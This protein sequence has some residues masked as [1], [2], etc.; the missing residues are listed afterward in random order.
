MSNLTG[1]P[2]IPLQCVAI[3]EILSQFTLDFLH[4]EFMGFP[5]KLI[6]SQSINIITW[7]V[8]I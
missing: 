6:D 5:V 4:Q 2:L 3:K 8:T 1:T 7:S